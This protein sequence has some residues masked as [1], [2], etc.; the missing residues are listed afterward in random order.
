MELRRLETPQDDP[1]LRQIAEWDKDVPEWYRQMDSVFGIDSAEGLIRLVSAPDNAFIGVFN[2]TLV[3]MITLSLAGKN[4]F[5]VHL[6]AKR[7][8]SLEVLAEAGYQ[9]REQLVEFGA[10]EI[11]VWVAEKNRPVRNLCARLGLMPDGVEIIKGSYKKRAIV[12]IRL[13]YNPAL[14]TTVQKAA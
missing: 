4:R 13:T 7:G 5:A 9:I 2:P 10:R 8:A 6:W 3:G 11:F 14:R 1:L 12:W